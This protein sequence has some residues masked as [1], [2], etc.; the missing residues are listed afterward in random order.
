VSRV[1]VCHEQD[2]V[3]IP[4]KNEGGTTMTSMIIIVL[5]FNWKFALLDLGW[6]VLV[7]FLEFPDLSI[8]IWFMLAGLSLVPLSHVPV[9]LFSVELLCTQLGHLYCSESLASRLVDFSFV[10]GS[11]SPLK[12][13]F[14]LPARIFLAFRIHP[15]SGNFHDWPC[16]FMLFCLPV[17]LN[18]SYTDC[19]P[20]GLTPSAVFFVRLHSLSSS[21]I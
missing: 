2:L 20:P 10:V 5:D 16:K 19:S 12:D 14:F 8:F 18:S 9:F 7:S 21:L 17:P 15:R 1:E 6:A 4:I 3:F 13:L 11:S